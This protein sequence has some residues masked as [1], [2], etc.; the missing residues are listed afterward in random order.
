MT[1]RFIWSLLVIMAACSTSAAVDVESIDAIFTDWSAP[2]SPGGAVAVIERGD[3]ALARSYGLAQLEHDAPVVNETIFHVASVSKQFTAF[4]VLLLADDGKL[5]LD[6]EIQEHLPWV[7]RFAQPIT[8]RHLMNHTS[9]IRDQWE[10]LAL[11][12]WRLDDVITMDDIRGVME[13]QVELNFEPGSEYM[14][15]N[16]GFTLLAEIVAAVSGQR[17]VDFTRER[18][19]EPLAMTRTH[20]HDDHQRIVPGR[21]YSY[22]PAAPSR[23]GWSKSVLSF[24]NAGATSLFTTATDLARWLDNY[25]TLRVGSEAVREEMVRIPS[26][27]GAAAG[28]QGYA[29]GLSVGDYR[30]QAAWSH[31]GADAGFRAF[32]AWFPGAEVGISVVSNVASADTNALALAV[33]D[34]VLGDRLSGSPRQVAAA[35]NAPPTNAVPI[36]LSPDRLALFAGRLRFDDGIGIDVELNNGELVDSFGN[37]WIATDES[38]FLIPGFAVS[39]DYV[40]DGGAITGVSYTRAGTEIKGRVV[41]PEV[42]GEESAVLVGTYLS[43]EL[44][45]LITIDITDGTLVLEHP[46]HGDLAFTRELGE[47]VFRG[48]TWF[49]SELRF[50]YDAGGAPVGLR[51]SGGRN[52]N[53]WYSRVE[54]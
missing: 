6:D 26:I 51:I 25:R 37:T 41:Q 19:F 16:M 10:L 43:P 38:S 33:A 14:Y 22:A 46:R 29:S 13:K 40:V 53:H 11:A 5:A 36:E 44:D 3:L 35:A 18:I 45:R 48:S 49:A 24:A 20:F 8:I 1:N 54:F 47:A 31:G 27:G 9:G 39:V 17:F 23:G 34:V 30:G 32:V 2:G 21:A 42:L 15:S 4:A 52:R 50:E 12:G 7:N 28:S